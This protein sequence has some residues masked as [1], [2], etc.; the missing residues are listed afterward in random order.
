MFEHDTPY[1]RVRIT[2]NDGVR[3]MRFE[4]NRQS[5]MSIDDPFETDCEY[6]GYLHLPMAVRPQSKRVLVVGLGGGSVVKRYW[7]D[8]PWIHVDAVELDPEIA[9][10]AHAFFEVPHDPRIAVHVAEGREFIRRHGEPYDIVILD[11]YD[12]DRVPRALLTEEFFREVRDRLAEGGVIA[13]NFIGAVYG[14]HSKPF[15]SLHRT[16][17]NVWPAV[18]TFPIGICDDVTD[19]TR[20]IVVMA[21]DTELDSDTLLD[22]I[23]N[24]VDGLVTVPGFRGFGEDF[25]QGPIRTGDVPLIL[26]PPPSR[27]GGARA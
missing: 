4:R 26:D 11:A 2:D 16:L 13:Y 17:K 3:L 14:P 22:R 23:A 25:Y 27:R 10:I 15:R 19:K 6:C 12:D 1:H 20:N 8:Y 24:R 21:S 7:R 9:E 5:T 18:W